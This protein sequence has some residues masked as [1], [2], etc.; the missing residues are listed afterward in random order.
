VLQVLVVVSAV[1]EELHLYVMLAV[2]KPLLQV[3]HRA[4]SEQPA[5]AA[6]PEAACLVQLKWLQRATVQWEHRLALVLVAL[7][8]VGVQGV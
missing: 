5:S 2:L 4:V 7:L 8:E 1:L 3:D 6:A